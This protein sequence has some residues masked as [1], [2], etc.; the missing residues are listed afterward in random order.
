MR[1]L[2]SN[3]N[4]LRYRV[5]KLIKKRHK[6]LFESFWDSNYS[7]FKKYA[8]HR[9]RWWL[10]S[11]F[12]IIVFLIGSVINFDFLNFI[13]IDVGIAKIIVDQRTNNIAAITAITL[14]V[15]G[16]LINNLAV[17]ESMTYELLFKHSYLYPT[18][19]LTLSTI[20]CFFIISMLRDHLSE[21]SFINSVLAGTYLAILILILIGFLFKTIIDFT[22]DSSI[23]K[24]LHQELMLEAK[25]NLKEILLK[26]CGS[27]VYEKVLLEKGAKEYRWVEALDF[28]KNEISLEVLDE[29]DLKSI[30]NKEKQIYDVNIKRLIKFIYKKRKK[31]EQ[32][33]FQKLPLDDVS[34]EH[35]NYLWQKDNP[36]SNEDRTYLEKSLILITPRK[37][38]KESVRI[39]F[40]QKIETL[41]SNNEHRNLEKI[42]D[43]YVEL[44]KLQMKHQ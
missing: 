31:P 18:I 4:W 42:L 27:E 12:V 5:V 30:R 10:V 26:R 43:S 34:A 39:Y 14:V 11:T 7:S 33:F 28:G 13:K 22:D 8:F 37:Q 36:N 3:K 35:N 21:A 25:E 32:I 9:D 23:K 20:G 15:V 24:L 2:R 29:E 40:D 16:F 1:L 17:K 41:V 38:T 6:D 44:Y 19:Y